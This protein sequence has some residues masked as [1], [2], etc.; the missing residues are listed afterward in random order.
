MTCSLY[1]T[2][3]YDTVL[4]GPSPGLH[5]VNSVPTPERRVSSEHH[6]GSL[7][8]SSQPSMN[9]REMSQSTAANKL[10]KYVHQNYVR[11]LYTNKLMHV[12]Y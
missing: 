10:R 12:Y 8:H 3:E 11:A 9:V 2:C 5:E 6:T 1:N 4:V 7:V